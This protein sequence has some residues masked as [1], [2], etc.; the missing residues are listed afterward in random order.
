MAQ[1][2]AGLRIV[3]LPARYWCLSTMRQNGRDLRL[4]GWAAGSSLERQ[5]V[6]L[7]GLRQAAAR[8]SCRHCREQTPGRDPG[9]DQGTARPPAPLQPSSRWTATIEPEAGRSKEPRLANH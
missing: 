8:Q 4:S 1:S 7:F 6:A 3:Q 5:V 2:I 9:L